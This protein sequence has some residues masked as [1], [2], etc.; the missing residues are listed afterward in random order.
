[1]R[2]LVRHLCRHA[3]LLAGAGALGAQPPAAAPATTVAPGA[4]CPPGTTEVRPQ[5][6]QAPELPPPSIVDYR[7]RSTLVGAAHPVPRA[8]YPAVD[9]HGHPTGLL[10]GP[11]GLARLGAAM[12]SLNL[13]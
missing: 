7:P 3:A 1:V 10:D 8:R 5:R 12:D 2:R 9:F 6:C 13:G 4:P 11:P